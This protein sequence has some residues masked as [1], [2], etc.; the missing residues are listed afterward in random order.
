MHRRKLVPVDGYVYDG[1][2]NSTPNAGRQGC[3]FHVRVDMTFLGR[4]PYAGP[5]NILPGSGDY[6]TMTVAV[7]NRWAMGVS[8]AADGRSVPY[9]RSGVS[10]LPLL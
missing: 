6:R 2:D 4:F 10:T 7:D 9:Y 1:I 3:I 8:V 5:D